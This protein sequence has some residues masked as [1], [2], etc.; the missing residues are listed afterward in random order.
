MLLYDSATVRYIA[1]FS[2]LRFLPT[3]LPSRTTNTF[4]PKLHNAVRYHP[5][6][7]GRVRRCITAVP[8]SAQI[9]DVK[10]LEQTFLWFVSVPIAVAVELVAPV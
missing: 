6:K 5:A 7:L 2:Y 1:S 9:C 8:R 3:A 10:V 4:F